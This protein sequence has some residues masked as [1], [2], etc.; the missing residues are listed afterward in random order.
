MVRRRLRSSQQ[1]RHEQ[2]G[3][4]EVPDH[5]R[6]PLKVVSI[7]RQPVNGRPHYTTAIHVTWISN[8]IHATTVLRGY[9]RVAEQDVKLGLLAQELLSR[10]L[11]RR[12]ASE[13]KLQK[14]GFLPNFFLQRNDGGVRIFLATRGEVNFR[15]VP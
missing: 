1:C 7:L 12:Q 9:L 10:L 5:V 15:V 8:R 14:N 3:E 11:D 13:V 2:F 4:V 6:P